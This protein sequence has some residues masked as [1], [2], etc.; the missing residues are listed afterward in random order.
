M[1]NKTMQLEYYSIII[2]GIVQLNKIIRILT[3]N[4]KY[5]LQ[6]LHGRPSLKIYFSDLNKIH[7]I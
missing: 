2:V 7:N 1:Y 6:L 4:F 3:C 5:C